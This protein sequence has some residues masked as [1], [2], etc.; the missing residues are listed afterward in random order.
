MNLW[1]SVW[2]AMNMV[3]ELLWHELP[4]KE[5]RLFLSTL[6]SK[7]MSLRV[8]IPA[9][10]ARKLLLLLEEGRTA[11]AWW[12]YARAP[13]QLRRPVL[14]LAL[15]A[16]MW[17]IGSVVWEAFYLAAGN[18]V[19]RP[20]GVWDAFFIAAQ[21]LVIAALVVA[22]R[23]LIS[24]RLATLDVV[25]VTAAGIALAAPFVRPASAIKVATPELFMMPRWA[26][27]K[28][29]CRHGPA[30]QASSSGWRSFCM[31]S[32]LRK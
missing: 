22:M 5:K 14:L 15:G 4:L 13:A 10:S 26:S 2:S 20:P 25:I 17:L 21:L 31:A 8:G 30:S 3:V 19:P 9:R 23:S 29:I 27:S 6:Y 24:V 1:Q 28:T 12:A 11:D 18:K 16:T 32:L 7:W